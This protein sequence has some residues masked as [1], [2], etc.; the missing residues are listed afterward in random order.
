[1]NKQDRIL[2]SVRNCIDD[3]IGLQNR[4]QPHSGTLIW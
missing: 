2:K 1:M 3:Q 4:K